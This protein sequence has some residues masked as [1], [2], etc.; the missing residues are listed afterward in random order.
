MSEVRKVKATLFGLSE[1]GYRIEVDVPPGTYYIV[2]EGHNQN[3]V[4]DVREAERNRIKKAVET[5]RAG[6]VPG[7][8]SN[9]QVEEVIAII[10]GSEE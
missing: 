7:G 10:E 6:N 5:L 9:S 8:L 1:T 4:G 3:L 2:P